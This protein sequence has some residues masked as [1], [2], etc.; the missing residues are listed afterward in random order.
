MINEQTK[1]QLNDMKPITTLLFPSLISALALLFTSC[2]S[3]PGTLMEDMISEMNAMTATL[4]GIES[5]EDFDAAKEELEASQ[6]RLKE[7]GEQ[8]ESLDATPE[9]KAELSQK[10]GP[11]ILK[12]SMALGTAAI[13][14]AEFGFVLEGLDAGL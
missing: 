12:A 14:A 2:G 11:E 4:D 8:L 1:Q 10:H 5:Q 7:L 3:S 13:K 6:A 9:E